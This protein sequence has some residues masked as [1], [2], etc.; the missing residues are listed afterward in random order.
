MSL[1][2]RFAIVV[3]A[4]VTLAVAV[5]SWGSYQAARREVRG[6]VDDFLRGRAAVLALVPGPRLGQFPRPEPRFGLR[7]GLLTGA[8]S[9]VQLLDGDGTLVFA[10]ETSSLPVSGTDITV[11]TAGGR[12]VLRDVRVVGEH[13]RM[14]T[15]PLRGGGALQIARSLSG[16]DAVLSDLRIRLST[17]GVVGAAAAALVGW[18]VAAGAVRPVEK[19]TAAAEHVAATEDLSTPIVTSRTDEVGRLAASFNAMLAALAA[20]QEQQRRLVSDASHELRTPLTSLRTNLEVLART[21]DMDTADRTRLL[22]AVTEEMRELSDLVAEL[23]DLARGEAVDEAPQP[24]DLEDLAEGVAE[25][26]R[27]R[28]GRIIVVRGTGV[29]AFGQRSRL[30]RA[31]SNLIDNADKWGPPDTPIEIEVDGT[32][33]VVR[34]F[35]PGIEPDDMAHVFDRFY[36]ATAARRTPGSG[37]GLAIVAQIVSANG[38]TVQAAN[39][40]DGGAVVG[41]TLPRPESDG[42]AVIPE[43]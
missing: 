12:P 2:T 38:G 7:D 41:F 35:G 33:V 42:A 1:R 40:P 17:V 34:D 30:E 22:A 20:S 21:G 29:H 8:D 14:I 23:V 31:V 27:R 6:E 26:F 32:G 43:A 18:V 16:A 15:A 4:S 5:V 11:A 39:H 24:V 10:D 28:T 36:R 37:L 19:L 13:Y 9:V 25:R 3:A